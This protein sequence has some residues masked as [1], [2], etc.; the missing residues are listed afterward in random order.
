LKR[1]SRTLT[2]DLVVSLAAT[3]A[4]AACARPEQA[5][6][7]QFFGASRLRDLI[8]LQSIATV[9][10]EPRQ[11]GIVRTFETTSV[12]AERVDGQTTSKDVTVEASVILPT[13][14]LVQKTLVVTIQQSAGGSGRWLVTAVRDA[15]ASL[16]APRP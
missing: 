3:V 13:G 4:L 15:P 9:V 10:F 12:S 8:A 5:L 11:Q 16:S 14:E 1:R 7:E 6:L 2:R